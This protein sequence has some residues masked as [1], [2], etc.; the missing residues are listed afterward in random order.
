[1]GG[2]LGGEVGWEEEEDAWKGMKPYLFAVTYLLP[3]TV[4]LNYR[5][6]LPFSLT[7]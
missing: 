5:A 6:Y 7:F 4:L 3:S 1:M 2:S